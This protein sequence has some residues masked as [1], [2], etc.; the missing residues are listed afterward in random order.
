MPEPS[1]GARLEV[2]ERPP[3][4]RPAQNPVFPKIPASGLDNGLRVM[5]VTDRRLPRVS[6]H[7]GWPAGRV[8]SP[9]GNLAPLPLALGLVDR[10]TLRRDAHQMA[11]ELDRY[12]IQLETENTAEATY[13]KMSVLSDFLKPALE[14]MSEMVRESSF[15][16]DELEK[17]KTRMA[18]SL[19]AQR[20][21][22][23]FLARERAMATLFP[24]HPYAWTATSPEQVQNCSPREVREVFPSLLGPRRGTALFAGPL[25]MA[26]AMDLAG[27]GFGSW[28]DTARPA[29]P[30]GPPPPLH[31]RRLALVHRPHSVQ[32][33]IVVAGHAPARGEQDLIAFRVANQVLGGSG[34]SRLFLNLREDK[35]YTYGA[36]SAAVSFRESGCYLAGADVR[37]ESVA[38]AIGETLGEIQKMSQAPPS[39]QEL[40]RAKAEIVGG[41]IRQMETSEAVGSLE[42]A[43]HLY[44]L[45]E[46]YYQR[47]VP[48]VEAVTADQAAEV[49]LRRFD[50]ARVAITVVGDRDQL[51]PRLESLGSWEVFDS[52][53][54]RL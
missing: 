42:L 7:L 5:L 32:T 31:S 23:A 14:L 51:E 25:D 38:A 10:G 47:F 43:R 37:S 44:G 15:P 19:I 2:G 17:L 20:A 27:E 12:A 18:S 28:A 33:R 21:Q 39:H 26:E 3:A 49:S 52:Q 8:A 4:A 1:T 11:R 54:Q 34:S 36:Y 16:D 45:P 13:L 48:R 41:F 40:T 35:G 22:P 24:G 46:D 50:P 53:G 9:G 6:F 29:D 30:P